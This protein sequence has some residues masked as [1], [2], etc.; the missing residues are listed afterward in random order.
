MRYLL[1]L[2]VFSIPPS[3][4]W[5]QQSHLDH[6]QSNGQQDMQNMSM[7]AG[8]KDSDA[9]MSAMHSMEGSTSMGPHMRM[10][11]HRPAQPGDA[12]RAQQVVEEARKTAQKYYQAALAAG[13]VIFHPEIPQE[14]YHFVNHDYAAEAFERFNPDHP[15]ALLY[16]KQEDSYKLIGVMYSAP[17]RFSED[18][19]NQR[20]PLSIAQWHEHVNECAP[21]PDKKG[22]LLAPHPRFGLTGSIATKEACDAA[23]GVFRPV[24]FNW[25]VHIYP[26]EKDQ[27]NIWS[28]E[29][30]K[31]DAD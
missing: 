15:T 13:F 7:G 27:A 26:F 29:R 11:E 20:I 23:G 22:D 4:T 10:T 1:A 21:P 14:I 16:E 28:V 31:R 12:E 25:M 30:Q 3:L 8:M 9:G 24:V 6:A 5:A 18:E 19:L 2:L 17:R